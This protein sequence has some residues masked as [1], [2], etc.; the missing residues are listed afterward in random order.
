MPKN[1]FTWSDFTNFSIEVLEDWLDFRFWSLHTLHI[2]Y[3]SN[4]CRQKYD[5]SISRIFEFYFWR[6][7]AVWPNCV[8]S[9]WLMPRPLFVLNVFVYILCVNFFFF[10]V[11]WL[12]SLCRDTLNRSHPELVQVASQR[13]HLDHLHSTWK[14]IKKCQ[15]EYEY[16]Y[17]RVQLRIFWVSK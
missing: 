11:N 8:A 17:Y 16:L 6:D 15:L 14:F 10:S 9:Q 7:F 5:Q 12:Q 4:F 13:Y 1:I 2:E 3:L